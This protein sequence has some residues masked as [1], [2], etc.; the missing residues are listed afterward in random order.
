MWDHLI[1]AGCLWVMQTVEP[2]PV[3]IPALVHYIG[4]V[5]YY[6]GQTLHYMTLHDITWHYM[7][8]HDIIWHYMTLH[9]ITWHYITLHYITLHYM[10]LHY[11]TLYWLDGRRYH[12]CWSRNRLTI[13]Q[14]QSAGIRPVVS[15][16]IIKGKNRWKFSID[17]TMVRE[18]SKLR[19]YLACLCT[20]SSNCYRVPLGYADSGATNRSNSAMSLSH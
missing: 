14:G 4:R 19:F 1:V 15:K 11:M 17:M 6:I 16:M 3:V 18:W 7:T 20:G 8:L 5:L 12:G 2:L 13:R 9:D 10:T